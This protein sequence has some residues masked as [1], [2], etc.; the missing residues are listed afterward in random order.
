MNGEPLPINKGFPVRV[1]VPGII[2]ARSVKWLDR[3]TV[4]DEESPCFYQHKD[5]KILPP[6]AVDAESAKKYWSLTPPMMDM[7]VNSVIGSPEASTTVRRNSRGQIEAKG[8][9]IPK[10]HYG[11][12]VKVEVSAD[13]G[14]SWTKAKIMEGQD[15]GKFSWVLWK[16]EVEVA[17]GKGRRLFSRA[18]DKAGNTQPREPQWNLRGVGY[19][20]WGEVRDLEVV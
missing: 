19:N 3:V 17:R 6:E 14:T 13:N 1:V 12:V 20:G 8:Y 9:A 4:S 15:S 16:A 10:G 7:P 11:P 18:T 5:Y 2:G